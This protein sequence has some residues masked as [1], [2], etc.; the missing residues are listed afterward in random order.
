MK[1]ELLRYIRENASNVFSLIIKV[2]LIHYKG[3]TYSFSK[4][5]ILN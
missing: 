4:E 2:L 5:I 1:V 3:I